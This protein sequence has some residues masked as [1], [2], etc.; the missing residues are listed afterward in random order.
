MSKPL[1]L[2]T[3]YKQNYFVSWNNYAEE[4]ENSMIFSYGTKLKFGNNFAL[5]GSFGYNLYDAGKVDPE[6][7]KQYTHKA[8]AEVKA[9]YTQPLGKTE[10]IN[11]DMSFQARGRFFVEEG[12]AGKT[13]WQNRYTASI[14]AK[15]GVC[16]TYITGGVARS[17]KGTTGTMFFG[18]EISFPFGLSAYVEPIQLNFKGAK[19]GFEANVGATYTIQ[20]S[21][22]QPKSIVG[23]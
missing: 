18:E 1:S 16:T 2:N 21:P 13:S 7:G 14:N 3:N 23:D 15:H 17:P 4:T 22:K 19:V 12:L 5:A 8:V 10:N 9:T 11:W 6:T 20:N